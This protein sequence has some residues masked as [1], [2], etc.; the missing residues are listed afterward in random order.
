MPLPIMFHFDGVR[1]DFDQPHNHMAIFAEASL[2][3][4]FDHK[5][6]KQFDHKMVKQF[7]QCSLNL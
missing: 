4:K 5:M 7:D 3:Q 2:D 6:V 1:V